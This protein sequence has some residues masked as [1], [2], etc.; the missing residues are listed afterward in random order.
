M[1]RS[2]LAFMLIALLLISFSGAS[3]LADDK[4]K[5]AILIVAFGTSVESGKAAYARVEEQ[6]KAA[7]PGRGV[8]WA[9]TA[10][11]LLKTSTP[12][13]LSPQEAMAGLATEG[14][15]ELDVL[16]LHI[17]PG[18]EY[19]NLQRT[20][21]AFEGLP[22]GLERIRLAP[23]LL[24]DT[25]S[26]GEVAKLL[27][28]NAPKTRKANEALVFVGHGTHH[29]SGVYYP[30]LQYYMSQL[31]KNAFIGTV[32][33]SPD[34]EAVMAA[35]KEKGVK[36][37]WLA[38]LMT[39]AGDH[40]LN[41]LFGDKADSWTKQFEAEGVKVEA[42]KKGLGEYP[43]FVVRWVEGLKESAGAE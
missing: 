27:L 26:A 1:K 6:V 8:C 32:E 28:K 42:V 37:L 31:D 7:F 23:P 16:S 43:D 29:P 40:A 2:R 24:A 21:E 36:K 14:V 15:K 20:V 30:A 18:A 39:V 3:A 33:G 34:L 13:V 22:K 38:P 41:D 5:P 17:I 19:S 12:P 35:I 25:D 4:A 10:H 9:W 11:S